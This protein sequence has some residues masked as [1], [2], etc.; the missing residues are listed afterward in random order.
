MAFLLEK[1]LFRDFKPRFEGSFLF[2]ECLSL[3]CVEV[4]FSVDFSSCVPVM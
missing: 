2:L 1:F 4:E 3:K